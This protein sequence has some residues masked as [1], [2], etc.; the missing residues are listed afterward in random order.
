MKFVYES[1]QPGLFNFTIPGEDKTVQLFQG[2]KV[3]VNQKLS[4]GYSRVLKLIEEIEDLDVEIETPKTV[5]QKTTVA[6][7]IV[8]V[9]EQIDILTDAV[10]ATTKDTIMLVQEEPTIIPTQSKVRKRNIK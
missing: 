8:K 3:T 10:E 1:I 2:S 5:I 7:K 6:D 4:D 9:E